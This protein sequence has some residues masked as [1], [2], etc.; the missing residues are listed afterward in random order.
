MSTNIFF[1]FILLEA[2]YPGVNT[3][4]SLF[5]DTSVIFTF[6]QRAPSRPSRCS[7]PWWVDAQAGRVDFRDDEGF[8][9]GGGRKE[10]KKLEMTFVPIDWSK[11]RNQETEKRGEG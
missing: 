9:E 6:G 3:L 7:P 5:C 4:I 2:I 10:G 11:E 8:E 1:N